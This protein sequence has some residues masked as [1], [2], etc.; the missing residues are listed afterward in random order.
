MVRAGM[1]AATTLRG[2]TDS[3]RTARGPA[4]ALGCL[5][6]QRTA[7]DRRSLRTAMRGPRGDHELP[8]ACH[9]SDG[10]WRKIGTD[11]PIMGGVVAWRKKSLR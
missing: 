5:P 8:Y 3:E 9:W 11:E 7:A 4:K 1:K 10:K 6:G 2:T